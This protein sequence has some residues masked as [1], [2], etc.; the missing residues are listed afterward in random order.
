[1][2]HAALDEDSFA[3]CEVDIV[4]VDAPAGGTGEPVDRF[5]PSIVVVGNRHPRVW[6]Q[7]HFEHVETA[8]SVFLALQ[9]LKLQRAEIDDFRHGF[10]LLEE[11]EVLT[12]QA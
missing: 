10:A 2:H 3:G 9:E 11:N 8:G 7:R 4:T 6:L 12:F 5:I 1:M